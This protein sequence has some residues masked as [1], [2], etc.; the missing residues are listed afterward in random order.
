M[1]N[2]HTGNQPRGNRRD[3]LVRVLSK[4][5]IAW[6]VSLLMVVIARELQGGE[7]E[8][9]G[10]QV[11][12]RQTGRGVPLVVLES[13]D[14]VRLVTDSGGWVA[15]DNR[16]WMGREIFLTI[17]SD[18]YQFPAD[19]FGFRGRKFKVQP[20]GREKIEIDRTMPA[21]RL[22]RITGGGIYAASDRLG[23]R[24]DLPR[25]LGDV[26]GCDSVLT[27]P[28][29]DRLFWF[30][31]DTLRPDYPIGGSFHM[32]G[33]TTPLPEGWNEPMERSI[34]LEYFTDENQRARPV[35]VMPGEGPTWLTAPAVLADP[36][37]DRVLVA[38]YEK[39]RN[40]LEAYR[41][42]FA[43]WD[44]GEGKFL[45][46]R[47]WETRPTLFP[48]SQKHLWLDREQGGK[49]Y[50]YFCDPFPRM[51][52]EATLESF[53]DPE[54]YEGYSCLLGETTG[55]SSTLDRDAMGHV[56]YG[57]RT[58]QRALEVQ[59][60]QD[61]LQSGKI[62]PDEAHWQCIDASS[63]DRVTAHRGTLA[64]NPYLKR[65]LIVANQIDGHPSMLGEL[66]I[67]VAP[68][69]T[70][71]WRYA[72]KV[73]THQSMSF[74]NPKHHWLFDAREGKS[75]FLEGTYTQTFS[76]GAQ[77]VPQYEYNQ[78]LYRLD[79]DDSRLLLPESMEG[80]PD[81]RVD[82]FY[83]MT[84]PAVD[85]VGFV[86]FGGRL[87]A[88]SGSSLTQKIA[89]YAAGRAGV[90]QAMVPLWEWLPEVPGEAAFYSVNREQQRDGYR[91]QTEPVA[92]VWR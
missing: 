49:E 79:L 26:V 33:A 70:G 86:S 53:V 66:W 61:L 78:I 67:A 22:Y 72:T 37:G 71:P 80:G 36:K 21:Q 6:L 9:Y 56:R 27:V 41:W 23:E 84:R 91:L 81:W 7:V 83:A 47:Q 28:F 13:V 62:L 30:W 88:V 45:P 63:G 87:Q 38:P 34:P 75:I 11:V 3:L 2:H 59:E 89:F 15:I 73:I 69:M 85:L 92:W 50:L 76:R 52:V 54:K 58:G 48:S 64:W 8:P 12:D 1:G 16:Q 17:S 18:G 31:G 42:G 43:I 40:G 77:A 29:G 24:R 19:G 55:P 39:I 14:R 10:I 20:G 32:T 46:F 60:E 5:A 51:R 68:S 25:P 90:H 4:P 82:R 57:W 74:Y 65:W 35:A 44:E